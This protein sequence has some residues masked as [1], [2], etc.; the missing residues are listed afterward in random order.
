MKLK[1]G[2][3][4]LVSEILGLKRFASQAILQVIRVRLSSHLSSILLFWSS[5]IVKNIL[6]PRGVVFEK[7]G[8]NFENTP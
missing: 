2:V 8:R 1:I 7:V 4:E 6:C 5:I 3:R